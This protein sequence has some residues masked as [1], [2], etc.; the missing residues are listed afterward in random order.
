MTTLKEKLADWFCEYFV[1]ITFVI[2]LLAAVILYA[3]KGC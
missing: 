2:A 3:V 1:D